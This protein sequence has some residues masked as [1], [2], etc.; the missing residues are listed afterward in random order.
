MEEETFARWV[1]LPDAQPV[2]YGDLPGLIAGALHESELAQVA[3]EI[4]LEAELKALVDSGALM[5]RD[6]LT[7]G[8]HPF[9]LGDALRRAV[10]LPSEDLRPLLA[11]RGIGLRLSSC[12]TGPTHWTI[13]KAAAEEWKELAREEARKIIKQDA[14]RDFY[15]SQQNIA[16][17]I[18]ADF[19]SRKPPIVGADGKPLSG[20]TIKRHALRGINSAVKRSQSMKIG[21]GK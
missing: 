4:N 19:R 10:L 3:A 12:R 21:R 17:R 9:P 5:V 1:E 2:R 20:A 6:P 13:E 8:R 7:L 11:S 15:P 18:A 16:D 14:S